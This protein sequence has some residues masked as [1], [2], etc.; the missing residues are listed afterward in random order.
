MNDILEIADMLLSNKD[1]L[2]Q[3]EYGWPLKA[4]SQPHQKEVFNYVIKN[5]TIMPR[6]TLR[7]VIEKIP[8][9]LKKVAMEK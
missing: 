2:V 9:E 3:K 1:D 5:K 7:Y 4:A 8:K 6:T